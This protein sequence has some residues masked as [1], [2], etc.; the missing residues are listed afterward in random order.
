MNHHALCDS[1]YVAVWNGQ[2]SPVVSV[3]QKSEEGVSWGNGWRKL[4]CRG[5]QRPCRVAEMFP[6]VAVVLVTWVGTSVKT[7]LSA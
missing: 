6:I 5:L 2:R 7:R 1:T 4:A 3:E